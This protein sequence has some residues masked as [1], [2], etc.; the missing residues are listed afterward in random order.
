MRIERRGSPANTKYY[1]VKDIRIGKRSTHL[2]KYVGTKRPSPRE[3]KAYE[4]KFALG[5]ELKAANAAG[6]LGAIVYKT[7]YLTESQVSALEEIRYLAKRINDILTKSEL[8]AYEQ[9]FEL[10]YVHG[11][12]A[13]EGNTLTLPEAS[14][15]IINDIIPHKRSLREV[16]EVQNFKAVKAYRDSYK[17]KVNLPF[18]RRLHSLIMRNIDEESSGRFRR[19]DDIGIQGID[20]SLSPSMLIEEEL[21][22]AIWEYYRHLKEGYH[23]F[24]EAV[25]FHYTFETIHPFADGNGRVGREILNYMLARKG[26]SRLLITRNERA[27]YLEA[28]RSGN[29]GQFSGMAS[30]FADICIHERYNIL[31][32]NIRKL[33]SIPDRDDIWL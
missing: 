23:P 18:I 30:K 26:Y 31:H 3:L 21:E 12:T 15:L 25:L 16:N 8:D 9:Q 2:K 20:I 32:K 22:R 28:L 27:D 5:L 6:R 29:E 33:L 10:K 17:G 13:I 19:T 24:E 4:K 11:T 1:L 7:Q 14:D